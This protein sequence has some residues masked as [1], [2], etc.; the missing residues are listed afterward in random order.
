MRTVRRRLRVLATTWVV[1][2]ALSLS[3]LVPPSCCL[4]PRAS[5]VPASVAPC[6]MHAADA[7]HHHA[8]APASKPAPECAMRAACGAQA[9]ALFAA[10]SNIGVLEDAIRLADSPSTAPLP[11]SQALLIAQFQ[12]PDAP[13]PRVS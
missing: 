4:G 5:A 8:A 10:L 6:P 2:Q 9:A 1:F 13:P 7:G 3:A 12:T 11:T